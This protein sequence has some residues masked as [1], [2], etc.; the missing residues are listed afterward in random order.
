[1]KTTLVIG[2]SENTDRYSNRAVRMLRKYN[3]PVIAIGSKAGEIDGV[4]IQTG[5]PEIGK[6]DTITLY[7]GEKNQPAY[8]DYILNLKP[9]R[10]IFNPGAENRELEK[11]LEEKGI[12]AIE[13]CTLVMLSTGS[14]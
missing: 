10:V 11:R 9:A 6:I 12:E 3:H 5:L 1:M 8:Y 7:I 4:K 13:A 2:A 14:Y